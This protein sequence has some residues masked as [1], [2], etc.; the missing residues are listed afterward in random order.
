MSLFRKTTAIALLALISSPVSAQTPTPGSGQPGLG[1]R[2]KPTSNVGDILLDVFDQGGDLIDSV[3]AQ[4]AAAQEV[5]IQ[6]GAIESGG[7]WQACDDVMALFGEAY[8][9]VPP[10]TAIDGVYNLPFASVGVDGTVGPL[11]TSLEQG[12]ALISSLVLGDLSANTTSLPPDLQQVSDTLDSLGVSARYIYAARFASAIDPEQ[13]V[14]QFGFAY[15]VQFQ[16][17]PLMTFAPLGTAL[18]V[19]ASLTDYVQIFADAFGLTITVLPTQGMT[20]APADNATDSLDKL[21]E[22]LETA[23]ANYLAALAG[24]VNQYNATKDAIIQSASGGSA[25]LGAGAA[26]TIGLYAVGGLL[27]VL[28]GGLVGIPL[29]SAIG[30]AANAAAAFVTGTGALANA[31]AAMIVQAASDAHNSVCDATEDAAQ[32][33]SDC[34]DAY[35]PKLKAAFFAGYAAKKAAIGC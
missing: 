9:P 4:A 33:G 3:H 34:F 11:L 13:T 22:C 1:G 15:E 26:A 29:G 35:A 19:Q 16:G 28:T 32:A 14:E 2:P 5:L 10:F 25:A 23:K 8:E 21:N 7:A 27:S 18:L 12:S 17:Q 24:V 6:I 31:A 30:G 20:S